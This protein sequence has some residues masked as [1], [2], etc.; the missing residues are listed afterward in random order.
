MNPNPLPIFGYSRHDDIQH[1]H[2]GFDILA[3]SFCSYRPDFTLNTL[4]EEYCLV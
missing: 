4:I 2:K 1:E 3:T